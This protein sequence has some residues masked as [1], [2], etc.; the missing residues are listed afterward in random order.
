MYSKSRVVGLGAAAA[1][2]ASTNIR[3]IA[4]IVTIVA[5]LTGCALALRRLALR[6]G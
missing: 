6:R 3:A 4:V 5:A 1:L 2:F